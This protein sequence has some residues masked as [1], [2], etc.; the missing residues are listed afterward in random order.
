[1]K[2]NEIS[3]ATPSSENA[4]AAP[5]NESALSALPFADGNNANHAD[6]GNNDKET[7][8]LIMQNENHNREDIL[9]STK[10][11]KMYR[12]FRKDGM[13]RTESLFNAVYLSCHNRYDRSAA[14]VQDRYKSIADHPRGWSKDKQKFCKANVWSRVTKLLDGMAH[15]APLVHKLRGGFGAFFSKI[16]NIP[17]SMDNSTRAFKAF[18]R[19]LGK[20]VLPLCAVLVVGYTANV[21][22]VDAKQKCA[23]RVYIDNKYVGDTLNVND[24]Y[25]A[26]QAYESD[27]SA[28]YGAPVVLS[29]KLSFST[30]NYS[31]EK[32]LL[33][34]DTAIFDNYTDTFTSPGYGLYIDGKLAAVTSVKRWFDEAISDYI[35]LQRSNY[36]AQ[37]DVSEEEIDRFVYNNNITLISDKYPDSYFL[38]YPEVRTLFSLPRLSETDMTL[39]ENN[40]HFIDWHHDDEPAANGNSSAFTSSL[41]LNYANLPGDSVRMTALNK[42]VG[43]AIPAAAV[44]MDIAVVKD[45]SERVSVPFTEE[46]IEDDTMPEGM[47]RLIRNGKDGEKLLR[48]KANYRSGKLMGRE[49]VGE[50]ILIEPQTKIVRVGTRELTDAER[51]AIPSGSYIYPYQGKI[52]STFGW[53]VLGGQ[54]NFHQG[55]DI[56]GTRGEPVLAADGGEVIE[57]GETRGYGKYCKIQHNEDIVT[58]YA[59]CDSIDVEVGDLVGQGFPIGTLGDTGNATGVHVHFE[60]IKDGVTV[61]PIPYMNGTLPSA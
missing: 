59:H 10:T 61:D 14:L 37:Y 26:K 54:N 39:L 23:V 48:Y 9:K 55:L 13:G 38:T 12:F 5:I 52:S 24:V 6:S 46:I 50:E 45:E 7:N 36:L 22:A 16:G 49:L 42:S 47:R 20:C 8:V 35:A 33:T 27:L 34:G 51:A 56:C 1:M 25:K 41:E 4:D 21:I 15:R 30:G 29:C 40:L 57:I 17:H 32:L 58:R 53:R 44:S 19:V 11:G 3:P 28:R 60:I 43:T 2:K 18:F 31:D